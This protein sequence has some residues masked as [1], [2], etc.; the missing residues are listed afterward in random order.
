MQL[1]AAYNYECKLGRV[2][3][4]HV[5]TG[6]FVLSLTFPF[7]GKHGNTDETCSPC[8]TAGICSAFSGSE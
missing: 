6:N 1:L 2:L 7:H 8:T 3:V 5:S 4:S